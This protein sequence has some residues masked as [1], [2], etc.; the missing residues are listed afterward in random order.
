[1]GT[2]PIGRYQI[3]K[4]VVEGESCLMSSVSVSLSSFFLS[5]SVSLKACLGIGSR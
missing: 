3:R 1:M 4:D 5:W 2:L